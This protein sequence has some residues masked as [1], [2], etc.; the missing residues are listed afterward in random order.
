MIDPDSVVGSAYHNL[1]AN[2]RTYTPMT[3]Q[4][5]S[6]FE[7]LEKIGEGGMGVVFRARDTQLNRYVALK[8]LRTDKVADADRRRRFIQE[9]RAASAL[10]HPGIV[11]IYEI[12]EVN[13]ADF[14]AMEFVPGRT[15]DQLIPRNG[16]RLN[17]A[18]KYSIQI[19]AA[20]AKAHAAGITHRDLKPSNII[21]TDDG[22]VKVVDFG[23]AKL[24]E[25][26]SASDERSET[27]T[28]HVEDS[29]HTGEGVVV[30]TVAYMS[31]EQ[32]E[33]KPVDS[34]SDIFSFGSVLYEMVTGHRAFSG[35]S[36]MGTIASVI[37]QEPKAAGEL[38]PDVPRELE[39]LIS[40]C[41]RKDPERRAQHIADIQLGLEE[42]REESESGSLTSSR[43]A[44]AAPGRTGTRRTWAIG[45][46]IAVLV[47]VAGGAI[48]MKRQSAETSEAKA[49]RLI[50]SY[51]GSESTPA[52]SPDGKYIAF[53][54]DGEKEDNTDI[55]VKLVDAGTP[56]RLTQDT[57][58]DANPVWS[59]DGT[60]IAFTRFGQGE[61]RGY[62]V[63]PALGG[64][65]RKIAEI[66]VASI[67]FTTFPSA[68]WL[69]DNK[70]LVIVDTSTTPRSIGLVS[71]QSG[72][73]TRLTT[74]PPNSMGDSDPRVSPDGKWLAF[75]RHASISVGDWYVAPLENNRLG[76]PRRISDFSSEVRCGAAW[77]AS[78]NGLLACGATEGEP[79]LWRLQ[80]SGGPPQP[81]P[82]LTEDDIAPS[83]SAAG[84]RLAFQRKN[85]DT[86]LWR[87][88]LDKPD[89]E[90]A[91]LIAST[92]A[93]L[94]PDFSPDGS[95]I[96]FASGRS[97][98]VEVWVAD[99]DGSNPVQVT[100]EGG[101]PA[102]PRWSP[103]GK[104][105]VFARR[106][107]GNVDVYVV[108]ARG[109]AARRL[110][111]NPATDAT[112]YW[113]RD[114][115]S[116]YFAS[117][118]TGR[119]EVWKIAADGSGPETQVTH[120]GGWRSN[121]SSDGRTLY[122]QKFNLPGLWRMPVSGGEEVRVCDLPAG[123]SWYLRDEKS[124]WLS[125]GGERQLRR[126]D[127]AT[128]Q[129]TVIRKL[130][131]RAMAGTQNFAVSPDGTGLVFVKLDQASSDI[132]L[133]DGFR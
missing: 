132:M 133:I 8:L 92:R 40:R 70:S 68:D 11:T 125:F 45:V 121:E 129:E 114:G 25:V 79:R 15:L 77:L 72:E 83:I 128:G 42:I 74:P 126:F 120:N 81:V 57:G 13:G 9:A 62:Y 101:G 17:L 48:L 51:P 88:E 50:T 3:G 58:Y 46:G 28:A 56:V 84:G 4:T 47:A 33:G 94:H 1:H 111:T 109:G 97:G 131:P 10:N 16:M 19:A 31:P 53:A 27:L 39:K 123:V 110:T 66:P 60:W 44:G 5:I 6:H 18:L 122:Y 54:W 61:S 95:R 37:R 65:E 49:P 124:Y 106:P 103:D 87:A 100:T 107:R 64:Q 2:G 108:S 99:A 98:R 117:N 32:A 90:P 59:R 127:H 78:S 30:G 69:P 113:S 93:E 96:V 67:S 23:L 112:A 22:R 71:L 73:T 115:R 63:I 38:A 36:S 52:L 76:E 116:V 34:R 14:I 105:I 29:R 104:Q 89:S 41:L 20:L 75:S 91:R 130:P 35:A 12:G 24:S 43:A 86:N 119:Q 118:R 55:Y 26:R 7:I 21:V 102:A 85:L 82:M 80:L